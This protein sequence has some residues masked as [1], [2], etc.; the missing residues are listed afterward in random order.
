MARA[1]R[2]ARAVRLSRVRRIDSGVEL[3]A[4]RA[5]H[6][7]RRALH[8]ANAAAELLALGTAAAGLG[9][10]SGNGGDRIVPPH[11]ALAAAVRA[12]GAQP[13]AGGG[14]VAR[15]GAG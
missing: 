11:P 14:G 9:R 15:A 13:D 1:P 7:Q 4:L 12:R 3:A 8:R 10:E 2:L 6:R 5:G